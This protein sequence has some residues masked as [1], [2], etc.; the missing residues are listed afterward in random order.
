MAN[1]E[2][3]VNNQ[4]EMNLLQIKYIFKYARIN[5]ESKYY[6]SV[7]KYLAYRVSNFF[8]IVSSNNIHN[9]VAQVSLESRKAV[10]IEKGLAASS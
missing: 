9:H 6:K 7:K 4:I 8:A 10:R 5:K 2:F 3:L 1:F